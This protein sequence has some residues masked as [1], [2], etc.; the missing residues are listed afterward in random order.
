MVFLNPSTPWDA[1]IFPEAKMISQTL[2][3]RYVDKQKLN[4]LLKELFGT[5]FEVEVGSNIDPS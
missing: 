2:D 3:V 4:N 1:N 5:N